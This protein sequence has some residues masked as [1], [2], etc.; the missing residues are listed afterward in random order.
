MARSSFP[1]T[2]APASHWLSPQPRTPALHDATTAVDVA[3]ECN[4]LLAHLPLLLECEF[5]DYQ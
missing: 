4:C 1:R 2:C 5:H 3:L